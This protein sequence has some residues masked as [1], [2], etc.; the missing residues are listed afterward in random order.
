D[1]IRIPEVE[2]VQPIQDLVSKA[3]DNRPDLAQSRLQID[4]AQIALTG[5]RNA[6]L[7]TLSVIGDLRSNALVGTQNTFIGPVSTQTGLIQTPPIADP[8]FVGGYGSILA[9]LFG[10]SF[11]TYSIGLSLNIPLRN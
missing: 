9:Q 3:L 1:P 7:P 8:F 11:P 5:T 10:R 6:V 4:N 2:Q